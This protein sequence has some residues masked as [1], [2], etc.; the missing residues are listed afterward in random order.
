M[1]RPYGRAPRGGHW[2]TTTFVAAL[3][4]DGLGVPMVR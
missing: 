3:R 2:K 4:Q 1:T